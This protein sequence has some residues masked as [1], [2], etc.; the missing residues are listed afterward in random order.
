MHCGAELGA[1]RFCT[2]C[3]TPVGS[4]TPPVVDALDVAGFEEAPA[5]PPAAPVFAAAPAGLA[6]PSPSATTAKIDHPHWA[7]WLL[8]GT[9]V[10]AAVI[11][12]SCLAHGGGDPAASSAKPTASAST[13]WASPTAGS[14]TAV[15][16]GRAGTNVAREAT[17]SAPRPIRPGTDLAGHRVPYPA[18]NML[19]GRRDTAYRLAGDATGTVIRFD[20]GSEKTVTAVG[21]VN[22]Y[23]KVDGGTDWYP[24][25]RRIEQVEWRFEDGTTVQQ[26]LVDTPDLQAMQIGPE[27]TGWVEVR[28]VEVSKPGD[29]H[30]G[31]DTTAISDVLLL[32]S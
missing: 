24:L 22:G 12:G 10:L 26:D 7:A 9:G 5:V 23:A 19:D 8:L 27:T 11:L 28:L 13:A 20:L 32:G 18:T 15:E 21:L 17:V 29:G 2:N 25:N 3:G 4:A 6:T 16:T 1:G 14:P 30:R 31:K